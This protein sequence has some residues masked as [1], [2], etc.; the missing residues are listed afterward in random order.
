MVSGGVGP[1]AS[2]LLGAVALLP[3]SGRWSTVGRTVTASE[4]ISAITP[5]TKIDASALPTSRNGLGS[6]A[7][8]SSTASGPSS[9]MSA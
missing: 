5:T 8:G 9:G 7:A 1:A 6:S 4:I 2:G 3:G